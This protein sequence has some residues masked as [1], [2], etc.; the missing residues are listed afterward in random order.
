MIRVE[1]VILEEGRKGKKIDP[2]RVLQASLGS[3]TVINTDHGHGM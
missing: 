1:G 3:V 2:H